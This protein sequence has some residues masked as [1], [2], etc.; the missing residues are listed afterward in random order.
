MDLNRPD[1]AHFCRNGAHLSEMERT[2]LKRSALSWN[3]ARATDNAWARSGGLKV[4]DNWHDATDSTATV[5]GEARSGGEDARSE[6]DV[7]G[8]KVRRRRR[9]LNGGRR[10]WR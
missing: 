2:N 6:R 5:E 7:C 4:I 8:C 9:K 10:G 3:R 1:R